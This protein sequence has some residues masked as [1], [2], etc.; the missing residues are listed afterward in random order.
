MSRS[1][2][3]PANRN[4]V[5]S[6]GPERTEESQPGHSGRLAHPRPPGRETATAGPLTVNGMINEHR[7]RLTSSATY[8]R[9]VERMVTTRARASELAR[10]AN[11]TAHGYDQ[12]MAD[13]ERLRVLLK[14][15]APK[16]K[17]R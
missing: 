12:V 5:H 1:G 3:H 13:L 17:P 9:Q 7:N 14:K 8:L 2:V 6:P 15:P 10:V 11:E 16:K 4:R